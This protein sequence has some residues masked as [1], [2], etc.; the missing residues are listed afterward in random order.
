MY[1]QFINKCKWKG[2]NYP[3]KINDW[4]TFVKNNATIA[5]N[6]FYIKEREICPAYTSKIH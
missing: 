6:I 5:L 3:S 4:K 1:K 2:I